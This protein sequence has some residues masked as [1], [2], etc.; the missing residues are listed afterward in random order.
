MGGAASTSISGWVK[1]VMGHS[2]P[3]NAIHAKNKTAG[4]DTPFLVS[5]RVSGGAI[6][7]PVPISTRISAKYSLTQSPTRDI[8]SNH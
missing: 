4:R 5:S 3:A 7:P 8:G 6:P 2:S 1:R